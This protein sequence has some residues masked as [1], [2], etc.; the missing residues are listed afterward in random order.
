[1]NLHHPIKLPHGGPSHDAVRI[2][3]W[4]G[5]VFFILA[6]AIFVHSRTHRGEKPRISS[7]ISADDLTAQAWDHFD[8][9]ERQAFDEDV[10][11]DV[12]ET[13]ETP[14]TPEDPFLIQGKIR[15]NQTIFAALKS[16]ELDGN[17]I[18]QV[19]TAMQPI[20]DFRKTRPGHRYEIA[21]DV[22]KRILKFTYIVSPSDIYVVEREGNDYIAQKVDMHQ[23]VERILVSGT[24]ETS[25][26]QAFIAL[27]E[28]GELA[29]HFMQLF[30]YDIDF[31]SESQVGDRFSVLVDKVTLNGKFYKYERVWAASYTS[32]SGKK[33]LKAYYFDSQDD[34]AGYYDAD[35]NA[36]KRTFLKTPVVGCFISS[37]FNPKR[38]HPILKRRR[39]HNGT[40]WACRTGTP[41]MA[42]ADGVVTFA[43]WKG[44]NGNLLIIEHAHGYTSLYAHLYAFGR[45]I[46][47]G[48]KVKRGQVVAQVGNTGISTGP[49]LH[50]AVKIDGKYVDPTAIDTRHAFTLSGSKRHAFAQKRDQ[51]QDEIERLTAAHDAPPVVDSP[52]AISSTPRTENASS[53][54]VQTATCHEPAMSHALSA[55][56]N[57]SS[58]HDADLVSGEP[59]PLRWSPLVHEDPTQEAVDGMKNDP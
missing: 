2:G 50:F 51:L 48:A 55:H 12:Q 1:M 57:L 20:V 54:V 37:P 36:L 13:A 59:E 11:F 49:H 43:D 41:V 10:D 9:L 34:D 16:H 35:G 42:F 4:V 31:G 23:R 25:L 22:D 24:I 29:S 7:T 38:M 27:G 19:I 32:G 44:G 30:K 6:C 17:D 40:D 53:D 45:G 39:P 33:T 52:Q 5:I 46:K 21:L 14:S 28:S 26:Y 18:Q 8:E 56:E 15:K 58:P 47:K 3:L